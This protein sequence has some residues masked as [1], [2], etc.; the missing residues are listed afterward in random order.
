MN[1][2]NNPFEQLDVIRKASVKGKPITDCYRLMYKPDLWLK[3]YVKLYPN[4]GNLTKGTSKETIDGFSIQKI[5]DIIEELKQGKFR[6]SPVRRVYI[7]KA[8]GKQRPLGVPNFKDKLVQEVMR[9]I[10]ESIYEPV[11]S[12]HSHGF[13][14]HRSCHTALSEIKNTW[15]GL[16]WCIEGDIKG[17][18]DNIDHSKMISILSRKIKDRRF[19]LLIHNA[20]KCGVMENWKFNRTYSGAPQGGIIS[21]ILANIY[22]HEFDQYMEGQIKSF[23]RGKTRKRNPAYK[24]LAYLAQKLDKEIKEKD[25]IFGTTNWV[26]RTSLIM[27]IREIKSELLGINSVNPMDEGYRRM[28]YVRYADDFVIGIAGTKEE[29]KAIKNKVRK[30][31]YEEL[32]LEL[33]KEKTL[34]THLE[35]KIPFLGYEFSRWQ[36]TK[37]V[38]VQYE[39]YKHPLKKRTLSGAIKLEIPKKRIKQFALKQG[40]GNLDTFDITHRAKLLNNTELE[41]LYTYNTQLRGIANYYKLA[42]NYHH[43]D[44]LFYLAEGSFVKTLANKRRST[45]SKVFSS[46]KRHIQ[47]ELCLLTKNKDGKVKTHKLVK[48][49]HLPKHKGS[50]KADNPDVDA[51]ANSIKYSG[52]TSLEK[53]LL[54]N[55]CEACGK[56]RVDSG[57]LME[58]HHVRKLKDLKKKPHLTWLDRKMIERNRKTIVLCFQCHHAHHE[59]Q[60]PIHQLASRIR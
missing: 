3:A 45:S 53:R 19:L 50:L 35:N 43:L 48:L 6:F 42:N 14:P 38:K 52:R 12:E 9:M 15:R 39:N 27:K 21:P 13:R 8:N 18:F 23:H 34:I 40:Y 57:E 10:L 49:K 58:V 11:F 59:Q 54:A 47:G 24:K 56:S 41:I 30:F 16:V 60:I 55:V 29:A 28:K 20:L 32:H 26:E 22:L 44:P 36:V 5:I 31:L 7:P 51:M 4:P 46:L 25:A 2:A 33:S 37:V 17:F 1:M